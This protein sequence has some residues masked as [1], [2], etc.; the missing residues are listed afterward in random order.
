[1]MTGISEM[2]WE[3]AESPKTH[4]ELVLGKQ[5]AFLS[6][7]TLECSYV[8]TS[9]RYAV[10]VQFNHFPYGSLKNAWH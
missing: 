5:S 6:T 8:D 10:A 2:A 9:G 7:Q 4:S 3:P 1:M